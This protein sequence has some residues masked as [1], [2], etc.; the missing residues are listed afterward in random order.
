MMVPA[1]YIVSGTG[2]IHGGSTGAGTLAMDGSMSSGPTSLLLNN[3]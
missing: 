2:H 3:S 1:R